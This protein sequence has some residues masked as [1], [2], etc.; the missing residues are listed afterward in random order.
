MSAFFAKRNSAVIQIRK[1][2][3]HF[4]KIHDSL[5]TVTKNFTHDLRITKPIPSLNGIL[6]MFIKI[7]TCRGDRSDTS[8]CI[9]CI[10]FRFIFLGKDCY[11]ISCLC[12]F[13]GKLKPAMPLL[14]DYQIIL[15][16]DPFAH[17]NGM[18]SIRRIASSHTATTSMDRP[19]STSDSGCIVSRSTTSA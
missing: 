12:D 16:L 11:P 18:L 8:L 17:S 4:R 15:E 13:K 1:S 3:T 7:I 5:G 6:N 14:D 2:Y 19:S 9:I 10:G